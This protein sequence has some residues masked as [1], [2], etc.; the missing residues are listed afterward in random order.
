M[1]LFATA[2]PKGEDNQHK[3]VFLR[4]CDVNELVSNGSLVNLPLHIEHCSENI[5]EI[6]S[7]WQHNNRIDCVLRINDNSIESLVAQKFV[8]NGLCPEL[9][10][11]YSV[12]MQNSK[13]GLKGEKKELIE[14]SL[15]KKG[16]R[17]DCHIHAFSK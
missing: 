2:N 1:L 12:T 10:L 4:E 6:V 14:V 13:D 8:Q 7:A 11:S 3:G 16:A 15:V 17:P 5:G 9:S